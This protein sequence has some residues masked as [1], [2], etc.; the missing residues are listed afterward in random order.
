MFHQSHQVNDRKFR[1]LQILNTRPLKK[2]IPPLGYIKH[3][4]KK[5]NFRLKNKKHTLVGTIF[6]A[7]TTTMIGFWKPPLDIYKL[8]WFAEKA[9]LH[10][11]RF[12]LVQ[13]I[14]FLSYY[15]CSTEISNPKQKCSRK[16][17]YLLLRV[18][19]YRHLLHIVQTRPPLEL[20]ICSTYFNAAKLMNLKHVFWLRCFWLNILQQLKLSSFAQKLTDIVCSDKIIFCKSRKKSL[21]RRLLIK[22]VI[23]LKLSVTFVRVRDNTDV[24][25][26]W[27]SQARSKYNTSVTTKQLYEL[28]KNFVG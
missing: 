1:K 19:L 26:I 4:E 6:I 14:K 7:C 18:D 27:T 5:R 21:F 13:S 24:K 17:L 12:L 23:A 22:S 3:F 9:S 2:I 25:R 15:I 10:Y 16:V 20:E 28:L 8:Q 11:I